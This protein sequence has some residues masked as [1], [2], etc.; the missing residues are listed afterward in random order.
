M[1]LHELDCML[2]IS[3]IHEGDGAI[4]SPNGHEMGLMRMPVQALHGDIV[5]RSTCIEYSKRE[6][7]QFY[8]I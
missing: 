8:N 1:S 6:L 5:T 7:G 2:V 3:E 4:T